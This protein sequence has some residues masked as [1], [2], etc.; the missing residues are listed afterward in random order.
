[1]GGRTPA[2]RFGQTPNPYSVSVDRLRRHEKSLADTM[3]GW[4]TK[5]QNA[6]PVCDRRRGQDTVSGLRLRR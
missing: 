1:M 3:A 5:W 2:V 6:Q 4:R